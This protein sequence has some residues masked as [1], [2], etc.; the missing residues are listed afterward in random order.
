[1]AR[2]PIRLDRG[3]R[4]R[5]RPGRTPRRARVGTPGDRVVR[6]ARSPA[7]VDCL[8]RISGVSVLGTD[9]RAARAHAEHGSAHGPGRRAYA[10][11]LQSRL[12]Q[13]LPRRIRQHRSP[14]RRRAGAGSRPDRCHAVARGD[15]A[16]HPEA[17]AR[18]AWAEQLAR[19]P[20]REPARDGRDVSAT[21]RPRRAAPV[22]PGRRAD[23]PH[24]SATAPRALRHAIISGMSPDGRGSRV[25]RFLP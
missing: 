8:G 19:R 6:P 5:S 24:V 11:A 18:A 1:V 16:V 7:P 10:G 21:L 9:P 13:P 23:Q 17:Q 20:P 25:R 14:R 4:G 22:G 2:V 12:D 15:S 3:A